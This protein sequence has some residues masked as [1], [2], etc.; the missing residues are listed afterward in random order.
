MGYFIYLYFFKTMDKI[1]N[2]LNETIILMHKNVG[3]LLDRG[4]KID[5]AEDQSEQL[6]ES[7]KLFVIQIL[8]WYARMWKSFVSCF[9]SWW[10]HPYTPQRERQGRRVVIVQDI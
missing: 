2:N 6:L 1:E 3:K 8:P 10:C 9:P 7:S 5:K 4:T